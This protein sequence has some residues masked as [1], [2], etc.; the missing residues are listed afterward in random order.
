M[1]VSCPYLQRPPTSRPPPP[2]YD[3]L[4]TK[5]DVGKLLSGT[6]QVTWGALLGLLPPHLIDPIISKLRANNQPQSTSPTPDTVEAAVLDTAVAHHLSAPPHNIFT[7]FHAHEED[8]DPN[9]VPTT[10]WAN[11]DSGSMVNIVYQGVVDAFPELQCYH[12]P[13]T[14]EVAGVGGKV[15]KVVGKLVGMPVHLGHP[16]ATH[17]PFTATFYI[18]DS[19]KYHWIFGLHTLNAIDA[20]IWC[21][22]RQLR[23]QLAPDQPTRIQQLNTRH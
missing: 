3:P 15:T 8:H 5:L 13:Y 17:S 4:A 16:P 2:P 14:H 11:V 20:A 10:H 21:N 9:H 1:T 22:R 19:P 23:Y 18:L 7:P 6:T 12:Q